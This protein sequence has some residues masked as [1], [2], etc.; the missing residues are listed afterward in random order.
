MVFAEAALEAGARPVF[1]LSLQMGAIGP[2]VL[3]LYAVIS[4]PRM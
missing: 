3:D 4:G 1:A 2:G